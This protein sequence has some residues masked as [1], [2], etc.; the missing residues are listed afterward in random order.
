MFSNTQLQ[1]ILFLVNTSN[2]LDHVL[3]VY[4]KQIQYKFI[5]ENK[6][7]THAQINESFFPM[8]SWLPV[9]LSGGQDILYGSIVEVWFTNGPDYTF[10]VYVSPQNRNI[11]IRFVSSIMS[12]QVTETYDFFAFNGVPPDPS[13]F[14]IP[15]YC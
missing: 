7:C 15:S 10:T 4:S 1:N 14:A 5:V 6:S 13:I 12:K 3:T 2:V 11:P 8:F 9:A